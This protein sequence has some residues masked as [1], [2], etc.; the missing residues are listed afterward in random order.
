[1]A[2][3]LRLFKLGAREMRR[4]NAKLLDG[5]TPWFADEDAFAMDYWK[6]Q[7]YLTR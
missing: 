4:T 1:L 3:A 7:G 6:Q 5:E 2:A